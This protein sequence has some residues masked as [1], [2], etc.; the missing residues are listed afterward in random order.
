VHIF[1]GKLTLLHAPINLRGENTTKFSAIKLL[2]EIEEKSFVLAFD[3][4]I[5]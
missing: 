2:R 4:N 1:A 3:V 5:L